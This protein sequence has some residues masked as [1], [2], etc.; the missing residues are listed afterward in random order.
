M[1]K[2]K[3]TRYSQEDKDAW[4]V[5]IIEA[6]I[7]A[8]GAKSKQ[9]W[10]DR[11]GYTPSSASMHYWISPRTRELSRQRIRRLR[12]E[13]WRVILS[14]KI[15]SFFRQETRYEW[16]PSPQRIRTVDYKLKQ[17]ITVFS[18]KGTD[19]RK[20]FE[21]MNFTTDELAEAWK[22]YNF[23]PDNLTVNCYLTG[24]LID[25][26]DP[27]GWHMDH[28]VP[29]SKGGLNTIENCAPAT[30]AANRAKADL[31]LEEFYELCEDV[32]NHRSGEP[33]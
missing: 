9:W 13:S 4:F 12:K 15:D 24:D 1:K 27:Y 28:I 11:V 2:G 25:L 10:F 18:V 33:L 16:S 29:A 26:K 7:P 22:K 5:E 3:A 32:L 30:R 19:K 6:G 23:N 31:L 14:R 21:N 17:K 8:T 20:T